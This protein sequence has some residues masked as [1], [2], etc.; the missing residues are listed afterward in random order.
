MVEMSANAGLQT[1]APPAPPPSIRPGTTLT[2]VSV[3]V[4]FALRDK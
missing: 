1:V 4:D 3:Q 2:R